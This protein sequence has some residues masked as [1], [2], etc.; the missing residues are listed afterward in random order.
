M[1]VGSALYLITNSRGHFSLSLSY[2][3]LHTHTRTHT[4]THTHT[5]TLVVIS[6][7]RQ[8]SVEGQSE[9]DIEKYL[10]NGK[11][12]YVNHILTLSPFLVGLG[13][14]QGEGRKRKVND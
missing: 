7:W 6:Q 3:N 2:I 11:L 9:G 1:K 8:I 4:H 13:A 12:S 10:E 14:M 5:H